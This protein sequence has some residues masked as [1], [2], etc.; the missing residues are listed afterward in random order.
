MEKKI[1]TLVKKT[2]EELLSHLKVKAKVKVEADEQEVVH[3]SLETEETGILIG[4]HGETLSA[5]QLILGL[6]IYK[7]LGYWVRIVVNVGDYRERRAEVLK[8]M[9]EKTAERVKQTGEPV[10]LPFLNSGERRIIHITLQN[11]PDVFTESEGEGENRRVIIKPKTQEK[12]P[13]VKP[14]P[15]K[16]EKREEKEE[17]E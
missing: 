12:P 1:L 16:H 15:V 10:A 4:Y 2:T 11:N 3:V 13:S 9:A 14:L 7:K 5:F 6:I 17:K 8:Q